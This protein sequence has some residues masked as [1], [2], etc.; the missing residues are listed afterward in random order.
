MSGK[1]AGRKLVAIYPGSFDPLTNGHLDVISRGSRL[2]D[3]FVVT[4]F[5]NS[6]KQPIF[7]VAERVSMI[8][9]AALAFENVEVDAFDG[10]L[11][12]YATRRGANAILLGIWA[13]R[14]I[15]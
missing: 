13:K 4:V 11:V 15:L 9:E 8:R 7:S 5:N 3:K 10:L 2:A 1:S 14:S 12:N 6:Q